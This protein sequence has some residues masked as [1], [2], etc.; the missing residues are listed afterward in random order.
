M[1]TSHHSH[2]PVQVVSHC[3]YNPADPIVFRV[4]KLPALLIEKTKPHSKLP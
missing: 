1:M 3:M 4:N 2:E